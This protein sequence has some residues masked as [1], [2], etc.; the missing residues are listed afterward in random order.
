MDNKDLS[1]T[2]MGDTSFTDAESALDSV[3]NITSDAVTESQKSKE[4][5]FI[6][7]KQQGTD[8]VKKYEK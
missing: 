4:D 6:N 5:K 7:E 8:I 1:V 2:N 3:P